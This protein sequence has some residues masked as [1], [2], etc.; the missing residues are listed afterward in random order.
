MAG[1]QPDVDYRF[2]GPPVTRGAST[3]LRETIAQ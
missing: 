2:C 1:R 3:P